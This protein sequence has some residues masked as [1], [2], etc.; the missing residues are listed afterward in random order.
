MSKDSWVGFPDVQD[1]TDGD[2]VIGYT[3]MPVGLD[4]D[5][6]QLNVDPLRR[7]VIGWGGYSA[8]ILAAYQGDEDK[9]QVNGQADQSGVATATGSVSMARAESSM[10]QIDSDRKLNGVDVRNGVLG[11][12]WNINALNSRLQLGQQFDPVARAQQLNAAIK[13]ESIKAVQKHN[14]SDR[15]ADTLKPVMVGNAL[16]DAWFISRITGDVL[17]HDPGALAT[18][19]FIRALVLGL[20][21]RA[22]RASLLNCT[23]Q[24]SIPDPFVFSARPTR[25]LMGIGVL[26][27]HKLVRPTPVKAT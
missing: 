15:L 18:N 8:I 5:K 23:Y 16:V 9:Y 14:T 10:S 6:L 25:A 24:D 2:I 11:I 7:G 22:V 3:G 26:A 13:K 1:K 12:Q 4:L 19:L 27:S 17:A 20:G 21:L